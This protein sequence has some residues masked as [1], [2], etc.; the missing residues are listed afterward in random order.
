M[1][2]IAVVANKYIV[3]K[4]FDYIGHI[5]IV[6]VVEGDTHLQNEELIVFAHMPFVQRTNMG[7]GCYF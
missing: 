1:D 3:G 5:A 4:D 7:S 6:D 2:N